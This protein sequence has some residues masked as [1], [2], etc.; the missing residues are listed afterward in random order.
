[1]GSHNLCAMFFGGQHTPEGVASRT[2]QRACDKDKRNNHWDQIKV[3]FVRVKKKKQKGRE[4]G[5]RSA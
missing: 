3:E 1:M 4:S 2:N 5:N